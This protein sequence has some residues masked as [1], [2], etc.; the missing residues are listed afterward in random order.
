MSTYQTSQTIERIQNDLKLLIG[1][2]LKVKANLG[3]CKI[4]ETVGVLEEAHP[5]LF[6]LSVNDGDQERKL[7]Y[8]Y[9]DLLTQTVELSQVKTSENLLPWLDS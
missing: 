8:S 6:I 4:V 2:K 3:R 1:E 7:S 9:A 5:K